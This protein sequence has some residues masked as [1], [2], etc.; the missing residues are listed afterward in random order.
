MKMDDQSI[1]GEREAALKGLQKA[2]AK[3]VSAWMSEQ[4][5]GIVKFTKLLTASSKQT[6]KIMNADANLTLS[7]LAQLATVMQKKVRIVFE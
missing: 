5:I 4:G 2:I 7:S 1:S 3:Q 6:N